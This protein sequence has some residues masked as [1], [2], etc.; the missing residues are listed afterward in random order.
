M[1]T[2]YVQ[3]GTPG[4]TGTSLTAPAASSQKKLLRSLLQHDFNFVAERKHKTI[5]KNT[6]A[7]SVLSSTLAS[8]TTSG[9]AGTS[10]LIAP[11]GLSS[12]AT[13]K[14]AFGKSTATGSG[15]VTI[16]TSAYTTLLQTLGFKYEN[17]QA[18]QRGLG[19]YGELS[20]TI[21]TYGKQYE[22]D[23]SNWARSDWLILS[24]LTPTA[25]T[26]TGEADWSL[27]RKDRNLP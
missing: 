19:L 13:S 4:T 26:A 20:N 5:M 1:V 10:A 16:P 17:W 6:G 8:S 25:F 11:S 12:T 3:R 15:T 14:T 7:I 21:H 2:E 23:E 24:W 9:A 22:V 27:A 18:Y